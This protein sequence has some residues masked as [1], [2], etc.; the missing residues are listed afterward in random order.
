MWFVV[1][2]V[3]QRYGLEPSYRSTTRVAL[4]VA[5]HH[6]NLHTPESL[7]QVGRL[8]F[9]DHQTGRNN[10]SP[11]ITRPREPACLSCPSTTASHPSKLLR[12]RPVRPGW[13]GCCSRPRHPTCA[14]FSSTE[15]EFKPDST[16]HTY[17]LLGP[18]SFSRPLRLDQTSSLEHS[19]SSA[20]F[21]TPVSAAGLEIYPLP[22]PSSEELPNSLAHPR[23]GL[24][25]AQRQGS[26]LSAL[27]PCPS[28]LL[29]P[30]T[31]RAL[32]VVVA[33]PL[34]IHGQPAIRR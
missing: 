15:Y 25:S 4:G 30:T 21:A 27:A 28:L 29:A 17:V 19:T 24:W 1:V 33:G 8:P 7:L 22:A 2:S 5:F 18:A 3:L 6:T 16:I 31:R 13:V 14:L 11:S 32:S 12:L 20:D 10:H 9:C 23:A 26:R 34:G